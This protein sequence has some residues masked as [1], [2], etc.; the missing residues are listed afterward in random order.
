MIVFIKEC[1]TLVL[2]GVAPAALT[3]SG[4]VFEVMR[5]WI[6]EISVFPA[7]FSFSIS[8][9]AI[10][11]VMAL[12]LIGLP[13]S[14][15]TKQRSASPSNAKPRSALCCRTAFCRSTKFSG[16]SGFAGWLGKVPSSSK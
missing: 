12:G 16:S 11:A 7:F 10:R 15:I 1:P 5:L 3:I 8:R 14:S 13:F 4:T 2:M 9:K 6:M